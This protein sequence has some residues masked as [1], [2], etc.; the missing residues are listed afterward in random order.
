[1]PHATLPLTH[2]TDFYQIFSDVPAA[3]LAAWERA[4]AFGARARAE[5]N[6]YW[7]RGEY[8]LHLV[9]DMASHGLLS[10]GADIPGEERLSPLAAGLVAMEIARADGSMATTLAV[11]GGLVINTIDKLGSEEQRRHWLPLLNSGQVLGAFGLTEPDHG[12]D[13]I[14]LET[15]AVRDG[16][17]WVLNGEKRWIGQGACGD[18]TVIW[19]RMDDGE[20]GAFLVDQS[21]PGYHAETMEGKAVLRAIPQALITL[22]DVR[23]PDSRRLPGATSFRAA[24]GIL[25]GTRSGVAWMALGHAIACYEAALEHAQNRVQFQRPLAGFQLIQQRLAD[26]LMKIVS[27]SLYCRRLADLSEQDDLRPDQASLAKVHNTRAARAVAADARDML[28]GS[29][30]LLENHVIRHMLDLEA[31]HTY[32][33][34]DSMQSLI[35]G[36]S[37]TGVSAFR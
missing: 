7:E 17:S 37:I 13:S 3:D 12:S 29:G 22:T 5:I 35:V 20:V 16:D 25:T 8:P 34:T 14:A 2:E 27:M 10:D 18:V 24:A 6:E 32:E 31:I 11:Q 21:A 15:T 36:K 19:A 28:G 4:A 9:Q 23:V 26:M 1:M 30:I 33:G